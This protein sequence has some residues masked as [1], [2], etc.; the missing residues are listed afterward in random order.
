VLAGF[1]L[2]TLSG[3]GHAVINAGTAGIVHQFADAVHLFA[4]AAWLG[5]LAVL[6]R[7]FASTD[8]DLAAVGHH[9][10]PRFSTMAVIAVALV[11][12]SG[13]VNAALLLE[14]PTALIATIY[15]RLL[16]AKIILVFGMIALGAINRQVLMP[17]IAESS[18]TKGARG[19]VRSV[20]IE[21]A[22]GF[23]VLAIVGAIGTVSPEH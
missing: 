4:A 3:V 16:I 11:V 9:A 13:I 2:A 7:L 8:A 17:R 15:G 18:G 12:L 5:G 19:L 22:L 23:A 1:A 10:L 20:A 21:I 6:L 14:S